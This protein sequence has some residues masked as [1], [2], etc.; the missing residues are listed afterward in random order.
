[1]FKQSKL[2]TQRQQNGIFIYCTCFILTIIVLFVNFIDSQLKLGVIFTKNVNKLFIGF[3]IVIFT[4]QIITWIIRNKAYKGMKHAIYHYLTVLKLRKSFLDA[5][6]FN[7][8]FYFNTE[9]AELPKIKLQFST[10]FSKATL[11]IENININKDIGDVRV[12]FAL[13]HFIVDRAYLSNDENYHIFEIY[14]SNIDQQLKFSDFHELKRLTTQV[15]E[16]TLII[17][18]SISIS[19]YGTLLVGQT[20]SGKT[21][22]LY[23]LILQML[24]KNVHYNIYFADP[25]NSSLAVLGERISAES[26]ATSIEDIIRLLQNFNEI[27]EDRKA[28]IK[29]KLN[30]K[31]EATYADFQYEPYIF[32]FDEF[33]SFQSVLQTMEKKKRDEVMML[34]SQVVLQGRQLGFFLWIVMQKSDA[35]LLPTNLRENLPVKFVLGNAEKQTYTT[36]FGTGIDIPEKNFALGQGVFTCPILANTPKICQFSYLDFDILEAVTHLKT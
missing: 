35:T 9:I 34:L 5:N 12:S 30:T 10:N 2:R 26:T 25:K 8:R 32:I 20:G 29:N 3:L 22:A 14:D 15:D 18:K 31:L 19:L 16:Y 6:Y 11:F 17:D 28:S 1:M 33:A 7:K 24:A 36:A 23:S 4:F 21:Y 27:M 13:N